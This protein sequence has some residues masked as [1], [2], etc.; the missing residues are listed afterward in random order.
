VLAESF[1]GSIA[2][3]SRSL[4]RDLDH[5]QRFPERRCQRGHVD[6]GPGPE[7][8]LEPHWE[9][10]PWLFGATPELTERFRIHPET[11]VRWFEVIVN[12]AAEVTV[13]GIARWEK[14]PERQSTYRGA[15][16]GL[17]IE[18]PA[19]SRVEVIVSG[20][21]AEPATK[22]WIAGVWNGWS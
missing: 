10:I 17:V 6:L 8:D 3:S 19:R 12:P 21:S 22:S 4:R 1:P 2:T 20:I 9:P 7:L 5:P 15:P 14:S 18:P 11:Y 13:I 16:R